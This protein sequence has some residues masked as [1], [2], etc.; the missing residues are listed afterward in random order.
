MLISCD[1][2]HGECNVDLITR[3]LLTSVLQAQARPRQAAASAALRAPAGAGEAA[4]Q[5]MSCMPQLRSL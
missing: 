3:L 4:L 2:Q 1:D 5:G